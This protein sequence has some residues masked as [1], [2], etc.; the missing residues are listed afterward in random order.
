[1]KIKHWKRLTFILFFIFLMLCVIY[2][3]E[4]W[5]VKVDLKTFEMKKIHF[6]TLMGAAEGQETIQICEIATGKCAILRSTAK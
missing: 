3:K 5:N 2:Y 6:D 4:V 1:M